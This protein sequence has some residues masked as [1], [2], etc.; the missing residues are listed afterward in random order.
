MVRPILW[1]T[2][3]SYE[4]LKAKYYYY[5]VESGFNV[6][7]LTLKNINGYITLIYFV[8]NHQTDPNTTLLILWIL[9]IC[10]KKS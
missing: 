6:R 5:T 1:A 10:Q 8:C 9:T 4:H 3:P 2:Y 7:K